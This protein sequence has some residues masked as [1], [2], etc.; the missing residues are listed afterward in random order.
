MRVFIFFLPR[1][2]AAFFN[3]ISLFFHM[4]VDEHMFIFYV[5]QIKTANNAVGDL[6]FFFVNLVMRWSGHVFFFIH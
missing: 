4:F 5:N 2:D 1:C 6:G 3:T